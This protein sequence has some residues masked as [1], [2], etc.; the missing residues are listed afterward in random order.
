[1]SSRVFKLKSKQPTGEIPKGYE[2]QVIVQNKT[3]VDDAD[4]RKTLEKLGF[5]K[6]SKTAMKGYFEITS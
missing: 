6:A 1:M 4:I 3:G 5:P 2:F